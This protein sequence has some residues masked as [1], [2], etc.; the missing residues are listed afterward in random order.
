MKKKR[1]KKKNKMKKKGKKKN[2]TKIHKHLQY[3][4]KTINQKTL[5]LV[6]KM[7]E[8]KQGGNWKKM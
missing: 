1:R 7:L 3:L 8:L 2:N 5:F 6:T 4:Y